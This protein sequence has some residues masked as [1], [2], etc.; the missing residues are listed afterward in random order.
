MPFS[1]SETM[2]LIMKMW[3]WAF[4]AVFTLP[5]Y[6][7]TSLTLQQCEDLFQ[8]NSLSLVA[9]KYNI[10]AAKAAVIQARIWEHPYLS[11]EINAIN[12]QGKRYFDAGKNGE[13]TL[14][15]EQLIYI[16]G[17]KRK[18]ANLAK[19]NV[20][21]A[22]LQFEDMVR[23]LRYEIRS[24][25]YSA[26]FDGIK[27]RSITQ[28]LSSVDSLTTAYST[29]TDKGNLPLK[30]LVR[31]QAL[32]LSIKSDLLN[33]Q[34]SVL[35]NQ[36]KLRVLTGLN[37]AI[38]PV[39]ADTTLNSKY[40]KPLLYTIDGLNDIA[41]QKNTEY[42]T[43]KKVSE[44]SELNV[45]WQKSLAVPDL[46]VGAAYDQMGGAFNN[47]VNLTLGIPLALWN[48]NKGNIRIAKAELA[49][50]QTLA[51]LRANEIKA[52]VVSSTSNLLYRQQ[53]YAQLS[54]TTS[55]N[56]QT[57]YDGMVSNFQKRNVSLIEFTDFMESYSQSVLLLNEMKKQIILSGEDLNS[58]VNENVF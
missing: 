26:Y 18:E 53:Q 41:L 36:E 1:S 31:L 39:V 8:Q 7:Q 17:Q 22:A 43:A 57:V 38:V 20:E 54:Q 9:E 12:P 50:N 45:K 30:D 5:L 25:F 16:A 48:K 4:C 58:L 44:N 42:L 19:G 13:K 32:A 11:G 23:T 52:K 51:D 40:N 49:Q 15:I 46:T 55:L 34:Q 24:N 21:V 35:A 47:Q 14:T 2:N 29:Q 3:L 6:S 27:I 33:L 28:Q 10:D 37:E 56:M